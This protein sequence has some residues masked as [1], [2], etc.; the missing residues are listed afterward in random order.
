MG[1]PNK[2]MLLAPVLAI[3][4]ALFLAGAVSFLPQTILHNTAQPTPSTATSGLASASDNGLVALLFAVAA[5][6]VGVVAA[7]LFFSEKKL[8]KEIE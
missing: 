3:T 6:F 8:N 4:L 7:F 1:L 5:I 2:K